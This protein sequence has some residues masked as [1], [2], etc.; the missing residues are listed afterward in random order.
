MWIGGIWGAG[1]AALVGVPLVLAL[2]HV[3]GHV[4]PQ[5]AGPLLLT[6]LVWLWL[7]VV[8]TVVFKA[9]L[10]SRVMVAFGEGLTA[11]RELQR[12]RHS[13]EVHDT[14]LQTLE[15]IAICASADQLDERQRLATMA[16]A[17]RNEAR[18]LRENIRGDHGVQQG[19]ERQLADCVEG[20]RRRGLRIE[21]ETTARDDGHAL[22]GGLR[23]AL[24]N[25]TFEALTNVVKHAQAQSVRVRLVSDKHGVKVAVQDDGRGYDPD[26][27]PPGFG[28][29]H[30]ILGRLTDVGGVGHI[31]ST[32]G[33]GTTVTMRVPR[34]EGASTQRPFTPGKRRSWWPTAVGTALARPPR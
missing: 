15:A 21:L 22:P 26:R 34:A 13:R 9:L 10:A 17:A 33:G 2:M 19:L 8:L 23:D 4:T 6:L 7:A 1:S 25:A 20:F 24:R 12:T 27:T 5:Q 18:R 28:T 31:H 30:S 3:N 14:V 32:P 11:G 16:D 29:T